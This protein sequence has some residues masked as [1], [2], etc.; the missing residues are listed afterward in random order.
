MSLHLV[1]GIDLALQLPTAPAPYF[2]LG[3]NFEGVWVVRDTADDAL[4][5][6]GP[7]RLKSSLPAMKAP[8]VNL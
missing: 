3:L 7:A 5:S 6:L 1:A 8:R 4:G 2:L